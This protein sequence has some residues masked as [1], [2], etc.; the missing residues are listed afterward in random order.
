[1]NKSQGRIALFVRMLRPLITL[2][3]FVCLYSL[4]PSICAFR[5]SFSLPSFLSFLFCRRISAVSS[6]HLSLLPSIYASPPFSFTA[7]PFLPLST[8]LHRPSFFSLSLPASIYASP[9]SS[10]TPHPFPPLIYVSSSVSLIPLISSFYLPLSAVPLYPFSL[11]SYYPPFSIV[12]SILLSLPLIYHSPPSLSI[13]LSLLPSIYPFPYT[14]LS[15]PP[16]IYPSAPP[17][18]VLL[19]LFYLLFTALLSIP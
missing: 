9:P 3:L 16:S 17:L 8:L 12:L 11:Y 7:N 1:M 4:P 14:S 10:L 18:C 15:L 6:I 2:C 5:P 13:P 19:T